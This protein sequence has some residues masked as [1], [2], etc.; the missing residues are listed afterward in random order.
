MFG[1]L[2]A[3]IKG[4]VKIKVRGLNLDRLIAGLL[5]EGFVLHNLERPSY[6]VIIFDIR[7]DRAKKILSALKKQNYET[8]ILKESGLPKAL[9]ILTA[10]AGLIIG[11]ILCV[12]GAAVYGGYVWDVRIEGTERIAKSDVA[13]LLA[14]NGVNKGVRKNGIDCESVALTLNIKLPDAA[15]VTVLIRGTSVFVRIYET[16]FRDDIPDP[17]VPRNIVSAYDAIITKVVALNG[18]ALVSAGD[19][20]KKGDILIAGYNLDAEGNI[21]DARAEGEITGKVFFTADNVFFTQREEY[22]RTGNFTESRAL[23][24]FGFNLGGKKNAN[25]YGLFEKETVEKNVLTNMFIPYNMAVERYYELEARTGIRLSRLQGRH[26]ERLKSG[27]RSK[28]AGRRKNT[29]YKNRRQAD[30]QIRNYGV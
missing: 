3:F 15:N 30:R 18:T 10:R 22:V 16:L 13:A 8:E 26:S 5:K 2:S 11:L 1:S 19:I 4:T 28:N 25:P 7:Y 9:K 29:G 24:L 12:A 6:Q 21:A 27:G 14:E 23:R 20:V 17:K